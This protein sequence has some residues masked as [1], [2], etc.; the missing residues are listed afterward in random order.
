MQQSKISWKTRIG[1]SDHFLP[2]V[3]CYQMLTTHCSGVRVIRIWSQTHTRAPGLRNAH[4][5]LTRLASACMQN[6]QGR[7]RAANLVN[8][9]DGK[10]GHLLQLQK[11]TGQTGYITRERN[12]QIKNTDVLALC[13]S[14]LIVVCFVCVTTLLYMSEI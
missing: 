10:I 11:K 5:Q 9:H 12:Y 2:Q 13:I 14:W 1:H 7:A 4:M 8:I 3:S 6:N